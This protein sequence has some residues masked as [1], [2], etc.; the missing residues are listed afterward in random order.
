MFTVMV[1]TPKVLAMGHGAG[2]VHQCAGEG[3]RSPPALGPPDFLVVSPALH[4][5]PKVA[6]AAFPRLDFSA[7]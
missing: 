6:A 2:Y 5:P 7:L 3:P 1:E 4:T